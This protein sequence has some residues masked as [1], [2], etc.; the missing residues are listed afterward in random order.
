[1]WN[2]LLSSFF[3]CSFA[4]TAELC[5]EKTRRRARL[6]FLQDSSGKKVA[7][8]SKPE[9]RKAETA[10]C[11]DL[12]LFACA[13]LPQNA[14]FCLCFNAPGQG[15]VNLG[16][17][18]TIRLNRFC[19]PLLL[20]CSE[21]ACLIKSHVYWK[22]Q[23]IVHRLRLNPAPTLPLKRRSHS[24]MSG[25]GN[26]ARNSHSQTTI[27][28]YLIVASFI[29]ISFP[30]RADGR[31][32]QL[33]TKHDERSDSHWFYP[34]SILIFNNEIAGI[35]KWTRHIA[36]PYQQGGR[37]C[38]RRAGEITH[39]LSTCHRQPIHIW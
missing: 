39:T 10:V 16:G 23:M 5:R 18:K 31:L 36:E 35:R 26:E 2:L 33:W 8:L 24:D 20:S 3:F 38:S 14:P 6:E 15:K 22:M 34:S 25:P 4:L 17:K 27:C 30:Q 13:V 11:V 28:S 12:P 29:F 32:F 7:N 1:M 9:R 19:L 21:A 37:D